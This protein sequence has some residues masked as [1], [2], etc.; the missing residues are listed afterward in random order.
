VNS[1]KTNFV[2]YVYA[3]AR[4]R[5]KAGVSVL[6][7]FAH[8]MREEGVN[9]WIVSHSFAP[10]KE[11]KSLE[12]TRQE[13][14]LHRK[15]NL[16]PVVIYPESIP[17]NILR[18]TNCFWYLLAMPGDLLS[19][20][21]KLRENSRTFAFSANLAKV[22]QSQGPIVHLPT[23]DFLELDEIVSR[24]NRRKPLVYGGKYLDLLGGKIPT[25]LKSIEILERRVSRLLDRKAFL[26]KIAGASVLYCFENTA[27]ALEAI[28]M[29]V[30]VVFVKNAK[31]NEFILLDEFGG[32]GV[33]IYDG[34]VIDVSAPTD[35]RLA[36]RKYLDYCRTEMDLKSV[37]KWFNTE[38]AGTNSEVTENYILNPFFLSRKLRWINHKVFLTY[39]YLSGKLKA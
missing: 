21:Y 18:A 32:I 8:A 13:Y 11:D 27:V 6:H 25:E 22:W 36:R 20:N 17:K 4:V 39:I 5:N 35:S 14:T 12:L 30:P 19:G 9:C 34:R 31:F 16:I 38:L 23:I 29:G 15:R 10:F 33:T 26:E 7:K 28:M 2:V 24:S 37:V 3:P 1:L